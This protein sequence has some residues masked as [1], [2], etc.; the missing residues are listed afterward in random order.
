MKTLF[1]FITLAALLAPF[2]AV[3]VGCSNDD[4]ASGGSGL[5][6]DGTIGSASLTP[7]AALAVY[8]SLSTSTVT[9][10]D[11]GTTVTETNGL[12]INIADKDDTCT[13][14]HTQ[15]ATFLSLELTGQPTAG[16]TFTV[17]DAD[18][19]SATTGQA[20]V[21]FSGS[22]ATCAD[23]GA[24]ATATSGTVTVTAISSSEVS[25]TFDV[26]FANGHLTGSFTA[27]IC[28]SLGAA[29][30]DAGEPACTP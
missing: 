9:D 29:T 20:E 6:V 1:S 17:I 12:V 21:D 27:P 7:R 15:S 2:A 22:T 19:T 18:V 13:V 24:S 26:T 28:G 16:S 23:N 4:D 3:T 14:L 25:G 30:D 5:T 11:G 8:G 10:D